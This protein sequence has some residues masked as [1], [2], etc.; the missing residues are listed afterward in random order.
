MVTFVAEPAEITISTA[1]GN[2]DPT[3]PINCLVSLYYRTRLEIEKKLLCHNFKING[4]E[5]WYYFYYVHIV[6]NIQLLYCSVKV[7][8]QPCHILHM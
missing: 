1:E 8:P 4:H 7:L 5:H 6:K 2:T 3:F